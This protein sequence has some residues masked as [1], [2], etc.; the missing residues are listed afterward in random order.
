MVEPVVEA[1]DGLPLDGHLALP[2]H[3]V[4]EVEVVV[5]H[6]LVGGRLGSGVVQGGQRR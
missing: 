3:R 4:G 2:H 1:V 5:E 6:P